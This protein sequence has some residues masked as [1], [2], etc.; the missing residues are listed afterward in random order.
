MFEIQNISS[1]VIEVDF[2]KSLQKKED[3]SKFEENLLDKINLGMV[4]S[5]SFKNLQVAMKEINKIFPNI[6][7]IR[8]VGKTK[9][10]LGI[11]EYKKL[12]LSILQ[13]LQLNITDDEQIDNTKNLDKETLL[14]L[15]K[16]L[17]FVV[18]TMAG[19]LNSSE[20]PKIS[21][22]IAY[23]KKGKLMSDEKLVSLNTDISEILKNPKTIIT[24]LN[25]EI[26]DKSENKHEIQI[27]QKKDL[28]RLRDSF[29]KKADGPIDIAQLYESSIQISNEICSR[30]CC[31]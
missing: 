5:T 27:S 9:V 15:N 14:G 4:K 25:I 3:A 26:N 2:S 11:F 6:E 28:F 31:E 22:R 19:L 13:D 24:G 20:L 18:G 21:V 17:N 8:T 7:L 16:D 1:Y 10:R 12:R 30:I 23:S 29:E